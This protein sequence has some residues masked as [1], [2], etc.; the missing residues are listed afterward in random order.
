LHFSWH[1][2]DRL[3]SADGY[4]EDSHEWSYKNGALGAECS[5]DGNTGGGWGTLMASHATHHHSKRWCTSTP[6]SLTA[7]T[8][9]GNSNMWR[10]WDGT[11]QTKSKRIHQ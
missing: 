6:I 10:G 2:S 1:D 9:L 7:D 11:G 4:I 3:A 8:S 5:A